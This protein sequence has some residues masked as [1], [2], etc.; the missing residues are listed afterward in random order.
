MRKCNNSMMYKYF[1]NSIIQAFKH[2]VIK[3]FHFMNTFP[4][5]APLPETTFTT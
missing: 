3:A 2:C 1:N 4:L 5:A